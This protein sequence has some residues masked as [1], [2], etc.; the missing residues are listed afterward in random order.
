MP[1]FTA[2][3]SLLKPEEISSRTS[4]S[5]LD[6]TLDIIIS[7]NLLKNILIHK[8]DEILQAHMTMLS[9]DKKNTISKNDIR[10]KN[11]VI[12]K[13][14]VNNDNANLIEDSIYKYTCEICK[15]RKIMIN[16]DNIYF[17]KI[18]LNKSR[19]LYSNLK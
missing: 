16:W 15:Q 1:S 10:L 9:L 13:T 2:M 19:S 18:Y 12:L 3:S 6:K 8:N 5:L 17:K 11:I 4:T 14:I 7:P